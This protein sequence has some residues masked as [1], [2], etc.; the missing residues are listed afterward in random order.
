MKKIKK[1]KKAGLP[2]TIL[3]T[4]LKSTNL[5]KNSILPGHFRRLFTGFIDDT[6][7][8]AA[9]EADLYLAIHAKGCVIITKDS[10]MFGGHAL[11]NVIVPSKDRK[12]YT[13]YDS[14]DT[15]Q[16]L[17]IS[18]NSVQLL[19]S[20]QKNDYFG[21][22]HGFGPALTYAAIL[23]VQGQ[24]KDVFNPEEVFIN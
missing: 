7:N 22:F 23:K 16:K 21:G 11:P 4:K 6:V 12:V 3:E 24:F 8:V 5:I 13:L 17:K 20:M 19:A 2:T 14:L 10:D 18:V 15:S 1:R 9:G